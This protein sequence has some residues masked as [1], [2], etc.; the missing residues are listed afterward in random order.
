MDNVNKIDILTFEEYQKEK[1]ICY[2]TNN[3]YHNKDILGSV[4][5]IASKI[6]FDGRRTNT[7]PSMDVN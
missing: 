6:P 3:K 1:G 5:Y 2:R 4:N 7:L